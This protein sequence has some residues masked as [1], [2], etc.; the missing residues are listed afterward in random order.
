MFT[1]PIK[2]VLKKVLAAVI[3]ALVVI[4]LLDLAGLPVED[5]INQLLGMIEDATAEEETSVEESTTL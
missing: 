5:Y 2:L 1:W 3:P 4:G